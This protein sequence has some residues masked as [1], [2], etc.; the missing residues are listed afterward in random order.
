MTHTV[1]QLPDSDSLMHTVDL[2]SRLVALGHEL[3]VAAETDRDEALGLARRLTAGL[4]PEAR[5]VLR[6][7]LAEAD[8]SPGNHRP[9]VHGS[10]RPTGPGAVLSILP[11]FQEPGQ[12]RSTCRSESDRPESDR[13]VSR[14]T[15]RGDPGAG[16]PEVWQVPPNDPPD[17]LIRVRFADAVALERAGA[18]FGAGSGPGLAETWSDLETLTLQISGDAGLETL[19]VVLAVLD[20]AAI[21]AEWL[22]VH[23]HELDDVF[24]AFT[25]L[26]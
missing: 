12:D 26:P 15:E 18:A 9:A 4:S 7:A 20:T 2:T 6:S 17:A 8:A 23:T 22:T 13:P 5:L 24:A 14:L 25:R 1:R 3:A 11:T 19:R 16:R 10:G 21:T